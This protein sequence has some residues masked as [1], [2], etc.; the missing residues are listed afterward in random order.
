MDAFYRGLMG[1]LITEA[2]TMQPPP[3]LPSIIRAMIWDFAART[4]NPAD[5]TL[6]FGCDSPIA[7]A[8]PLLS[9][10]IA[11]RFED[12]NVCIVFR[13]YRDFKRE[14]QVWPIPFDPAEGFADQRHAW[15]RLRATGGLLY[16]VAY[17]A[18]VP[19][20][21]M[22]SSF[23]CL[24]EVSAPPDLLL[25]DTFSPFDTSALDEFHVQ[26]WR[27][28]QIVNRVFPTEQRGEAWRTVALRFTEV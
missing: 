28:E 11:P 3:D 6:W 19:I 26:R 9:S 21:V 8:A 12:I 7:A 1:A 13:G 24:V 16:S 14:A 18:A 25:L 17:S 10:G 20:D 23:R 22:A 4:A 5:I 27:S 2:E 15:K